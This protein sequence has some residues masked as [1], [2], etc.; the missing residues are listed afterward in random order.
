MH[1]RDQAMGDFV[2]SPMLPIES[3]LPELATA[4][5]AHR[6]AVLVAE[7]G[8][9]TSTRVPLFLLSEPWAS[10]RRIV[11]LEPRRLAA[12]SVARYMASALG[13]RVGETVGYRVR[14]ETRVGPATRV[15]VVTE[16]VLT[17]MLQA[18][19]SLEGVAL[20]ISDELHER[21]PHADLRLAPWLPAQG[22]FRPDPG[23]PVMS[24]TLEAEPVA[25][26]RGGVPVIRSEGRSF[27]VTYACASRPLRKQG[28]AA[29]QGTLAG[30]AG[31][32]QAVDWDAARRVQEEARHLME[33][34]RIA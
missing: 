18:D 5:R 6:G 29:E 26:L 22:R 16:G 30:T 14:R 10:G 15:E 17:R 13:E 23:T 9:G 4:L 34:A 24:A 7:P 25:T 2:H 32:G 8:A 33:I 27:P 31:P 21:S 3:V 12:R 1:R 28:E 20:V 11:M 19:P